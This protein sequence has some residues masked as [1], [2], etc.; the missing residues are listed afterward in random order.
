MSNIHLT[1]KLIERE[2][3]LPFSMQDLLLANEKIF[4][5]SKRQ[6]AALNCKNRGSHLCNGCK[7]IF[8]CSVVRIFSLLSLSLKIL[9][10]SQECQKPSWAEHKKLCK[11]ARVVRW[12]SE[13]DWL[14][15]EHT[16]GVGEGYWEFPKDFPT[17]HLR[18]SRK[19][20]GISVSRLFLACSSLLTFL[21]ERLTT[22]F[23]SIWLKCM[24]PDSS[25]T[26]T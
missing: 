20:Q 6:C 3:I 8:Y 21:L 14:T 5:P 24:T 9:M 18:Q 4:S 12:F 17:S 26:E 22:E 2:Q 16:T 1:M 13:R 7:A 10:R 23:K 25:L 15:F 11:P 19:D